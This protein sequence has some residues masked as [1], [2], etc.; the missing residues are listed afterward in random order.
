[1]TLVAL[2]FGLVGPFCS[3]NDSDTPPGSGGHSSDDCG[4]DGGD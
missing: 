4:D 2:T 3:V 1:V